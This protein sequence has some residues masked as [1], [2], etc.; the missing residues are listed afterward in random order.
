MKVGR[1]YLSETARARL[2]AEAQRMRRQLAERREQRRVAAIL[3]RI[4]KGA[5]S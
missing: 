1:F 5:Q 4:V 3:E 2:A